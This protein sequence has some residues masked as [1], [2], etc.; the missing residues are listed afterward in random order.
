MPKVT[1][2]EIWK[3]VPEL[4]AI[5]EQGLPRPGGP[6]RFV[7][8]FQPR[9]AEAVRAGTKRQTIRPVPGRLPMV[10]DTISLRMWTGKP[11]RSKQALLRTEVIQSVKIC[12]I[13]REGIAR[14]APDGCLLQIAGVRIIC[15]NGSEADR[16]A[17]DDGFKDFEEMR[18][19][20]ERQH[21]LPF[22]GLI[23]SW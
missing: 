4:L 19:W 10:G 5:T 9:F 6:A 12:C 15:E 17:R 20:F 13:T 18:S 22:D 11:Y 8:L 1:K 14:Q 16:F 21:G 2:T 23:I 7:R 3:L